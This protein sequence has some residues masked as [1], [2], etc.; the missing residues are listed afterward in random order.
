MP[1]WSR[2]PAASASSRAA[3]DLATSASY[4][5]RSSS[6]LSCRAELQSQSSSASQSTSAQKPTGGRP[7]SA[8]VNHHCSTKA[9][10]LTIPPSVI[11][12][13]WP[14]IVA[15]SWAASSPAVWVRIVSR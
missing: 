6:G 1:G 5:A 12:A 4:I 2:P 9:R 3:S 13:G 7:C 10:C 11:T 14:G 8:M 15:A